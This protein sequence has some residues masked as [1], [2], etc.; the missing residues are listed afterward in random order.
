M[1]TA[2]IVET[3]EQQ[4]IVKFN[5][6]ETVFADI[7]SYQALEITDSK[8]EKDVRKARLDT[9]Q[10]RYKIQ[11]RHKELNAELN[12]Q[13][14]E[15]K[16]AAESLINRLVP[17]ENNLDEKIK[18]VETERAE[19][20][21]IKERKEKNRIENINKLFNVLNLNCQS[22]VRYGRESED[23]QDDLDRLM[24][25]KIYQIDYHG[26]TK[27]A[28]QVLKKGIE[29]TK[30]ALKNRLAHEKEQT[31]H[32]AEAVRLKELRIKQEKEAQKI[33]ET[34]EK[35]EAE[36]KA[37]REVEAAKL[38]A[39]QTAFE[40]EKKAEADRLAK[41]EADRAEQLKIEQDKID[42]DRKALE[43]AQAKMA[44]EKAA[45]AERKIAEE[46]ARCDAELA[47]KEL[48]ELNALIAVWEPVVDALYATAYDEAITLNQ[49]WDIEHDKLV[50]AVSKDAE[51]LRIFAAELDAVEEPVMITNEGKAW[52]KDVKHHLKNAKGSCLDWGEI[53]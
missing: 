44:H 21:A 28:E 22:G 23:I 8:S 5:I 39:E 30:T 51:K 17:T 9:R 33:R 27:E 16:S 7:E 25:I 41:I 32:K 52:F 14:R 15:Y 6:K 38:A 43:A 53:K 26:R 24:N 36:A 3:T 12:S 49:E 50:E 35:A 40:A 18:S 29:E 31:E 42:A 19:K 46:K 34:Q 11:N 20:K 37:K 45:E 48:E 47:A 1:E 10:L 13:K 2:E 4:A